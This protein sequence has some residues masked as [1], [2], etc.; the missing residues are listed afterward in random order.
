MCTKLSLMYSSMFGIE[1]IAKMDAL[2]IEHFPLGR[3]EVGDRHVDDA[4]SVYAL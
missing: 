2:Y 4:V 1:D 3:E